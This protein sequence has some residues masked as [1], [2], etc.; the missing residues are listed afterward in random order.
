LDIMRPCTGNGGRSGFDPKY[1]TFLANTESEASQFRDRLIEEAW[2]FIEAT[3][4]QKMTTFNESEGFMEKLFQII[5]DHQD[6]L[7]IL[8][9]LFVVV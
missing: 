6:K 1:L 8:S 5:K 9:S 2:V 3:E 4:A 7:P